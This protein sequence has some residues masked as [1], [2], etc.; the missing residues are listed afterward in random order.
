MGV[1]TF[2]PTNFWPLNTTLYVTDFRDN[3][4]YFAYYLLKTIDFKGFNSGSAQASL[5]R[6]F[7]RRIPVVLPALAEQR[8]IASVLRTFEDKIE[9][10][11]R[12]AALLEETVATLFKAR[13]VDFI[14]VE[15]F[16]QSEIGP[17]PLG[18][19]RCSLS[20]IARFVNGKA[21]TKLAN[22]SGRPIIRIRELNNGV[23]S[24]TPMSDVP[25]S[26]EA[27]AH[28]GDILFAWSGS[29]DVYRWGGDDALIN[30]HIF[31]VVPEAVPPWFVYGWIH[32]HMPS[33]Q[34]SARDRAVT[35][36]HI[37]RHHLDDAPVA[38]PEA[39]ALS[40]AATVLDP[41]D[42]K[43]RALIAETRTLAALRDALLPKLISGAI[44]VPDA[45]DPADA[46]ELAA[47]TAW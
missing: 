2:A 41:L 4:P 5:N 22:G 26:D 44:R 6:N 17:I 43:I 8:R 33:F 47:G 25:A 14:G 20:D 16:E 18:W 11:R 9:S 1:V 30:Q 7:V 31:K 24:A 38:L 32:R 45:A 28:F 27:I 21:F 35:M 15:D 23:D 34:A 12:L 46:L 19:T 37:R 13:F 42:D 3:D 36:G 39:R 10:N 40:S 29:L